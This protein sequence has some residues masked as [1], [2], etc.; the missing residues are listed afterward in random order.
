MAESP[1]AYYQWQ[2]ED[3][4]LQVLVQ[5]KASKDEIA[6]LQG[7]EL[8]VRLQAPPMEGAAN[9][10]LVKFFSKI[11]KVPKSHITIV[12]GETSRHKRLCIRCPK[13]LP[14]GIVGG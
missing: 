12:S 9:Q 3:L 13:Q 10:A 1:T 6:G 7:A 8:K 2:G 11:F 14:E 5:P 4:W